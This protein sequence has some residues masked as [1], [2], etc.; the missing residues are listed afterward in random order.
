MPSRTV[1]SQSGRARSR[2]PCVQLSGYGGQLSQIALRPELFATHVALHVEVRVVS[3]TGPG[4]A[5]HGA[6]GTFAADGGHGVRDG[7]R[8]R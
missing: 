3:P 6:R 4:R 5:G 2:I 8:G 1:M 7:P